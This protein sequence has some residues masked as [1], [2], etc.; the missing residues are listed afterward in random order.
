MSA[1]LV[2]PIGSLHPFLIQIL[3]SP[4]AAVMDYQNLLPLP[5]NETPTAPQPTILRSPNP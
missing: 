4:S 1:L 5:R 3:L 2:C